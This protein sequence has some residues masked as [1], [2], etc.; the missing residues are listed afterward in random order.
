[1]EHVALALLLLQSLLCLASSTN[2]CGPL[3]NDTLRHS[4]HESPTG[5]YRLV[6]CEMGQ[7]ILLFCKSDGTWRLE[8]GPDYVD[9]CPRT[10]CKESDL[11]T[12]EFNKVTPRRMYLNDKVTI[13]CKAGYIGQRIR[14]RCQK[15]RCTTKSGCKLFWKPMNR[16]ADGQ[17]IKEVSCSVP[18][19]EVR[20]PPF[21]PTSNMTIIDR[22]ME[23]SHPVYM[24]N[25]ALQLGCDE[26]Y[27][28]H[29]ATQD[30]GWI[31]CSADGTWEP[32]PIPVCT[33]GLPCSLPSIEN[34]N[35]QNA[36]RHWAIGEWV[37]VKCSDNF[38][39]NE[40]SS[41]ALHCVGSKG[42]EDY[43]WDRHIPQC[44]AITCPFFSIGRDGTRRFSSSTRGVGSTVTA[45]C[46]EGSSLRGPRVRWCTDAATWN[47]TLQICDQGGTTCGNP[48]TP[49]HGRKIGDR[50]NEGDT[51]SFRCN[52]GYSLIGAE[53]RTCL[54]RGTWS[55][56]ETRCMGRHEYMTTEEVTRKF[57]DGIGRL[58]METADSELFRDKMKNYFRKNLQYG[59]KE[60]HEMNPDS[61]TSLGA[62]RNEGG[63]D[64]YFLL[65]TSGS[66]SPEERKK[67]I[68]IVKA[69]VKK[70]GV[71]GRGQ[72]EG[73][74][75]IG[76]VAFS[77]TAWL[78]KSVTEMDSEDKLYRELGKI[79]R[80]ATAGGTAPSK[81]FEA[82]QTTLIPTDRQTNR[83]DTI[84]IVMLTD[85]L[86]NQG[87][88]PLTSIKAIRRETDIYSQTLH[89]YCLGVGDANI[90]SLKTI[91]SK[92][93]EYLM[94]VKG[95]ETFLLVSK[96]ISN[97]TDYGRCG[98]AGPADISSS[99][100]AEEHVWRWMGAV[101]KYPFTP[102]TTI[103]DQMTHK[104]SKFHCGASL[105]KPPYPESSSSRWALTAAHCVAE[106]TQ[107]NQYIVKFGSINS[108]K[109]TEDN[110]T[111]VFVD[112][113]IKH[114]NFSMSNLVND[115]ALLRLK[116]EI[117]FSVDIR[118]VCLPAQGASVYAEKQKATVTGWG[119]WNSTVKEPS[120][121]LKQIDVEI[122]S[123]ETCVKTT[124]GKTSEYVPGENLCAGG[125]RNAK[126]ELLDACKKDSG[127]PLVISRVGN[128]GLTYWTQAGIVSWGDGCGQPDEYGVYTKVSN[129]VDWIENKIMHG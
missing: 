42:P 64:V 5:R 102:F 95:Y 126:G 125:V 41:R 47:G 97:K 111:L 116:D 88:D 69:L 37:N 121:T 31:E 71:A 84:A 51:V 109:G 24:P 101:F 127:G 108:T 104:K 14:M 56:E 45:T 87:G 75:G 21:E 66:I 25:D 60:M 7:K 28:L 19:G 114:P 39:I 96:L 35:L 33:K 105:L 91:A 12:N 78:V 120:E 50:Y 59:E 112:K 106:N 103:D 52:R 54:A 68:E 79:A 73:G 119:Y 123:D 70:L 43:G 74:T 26:G 86:V 82:L 92:G 27:Q 49:I 10:K 20:C 18:D 11:K 38:M 93:E 122:Q 2:N 100:W 77:S 9:Q 80:N 113:V 117:S 36:S 76:L 22:D 115:I 48:G 65:D 67:S 81:A 110:P 13:G 17:R 90:E 23:H 40:Y 3:G 44:Q 1:M 6:Y 89:I 85:G 30:D 46:N 124:N 58:S 98:L 29:P 94:K 4:F 107:P 8:K 16:T 61:R 34:S 128:D 53:E 57:S 15:R 72:K 55:K 99:S 62:L 63:L 83:K 32:N 129:Y 118:P